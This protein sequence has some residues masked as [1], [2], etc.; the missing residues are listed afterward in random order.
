MSILSDKIRTDHPDLADDMDSG[1]LTTGQALNEIKRRQYRA[2]YIRLAENSKPVDGV[3]WVHGDCLEKLADVPDGS[4]NVLLTDPPYGMDY[5]SHRRAVLARKIANDKDE[6]VDVIE[7]M[8]KAVSPKL[9]P[10][11]HVLIFCTWRNEADM[12][13]IVEENGMTIK[14]SLI[15]VKNN[16]GS[17]DL[18]SSFAPKH[19]RIVHAIVGRPRV[20]PRIPDVLEFAKVPSTLHPTEKPA[21]LLARLIEVTC[22]EDGMV[23]DP[24]GGVGSILLGARMAKRKVWGCELDDQYYAVG[25]GRL[26]EVIN[27]E[28]EPTDTVG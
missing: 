22:P 21:D 17:G 4:I 1:K 28:V 2:K 16:H 19:E 14:G 13:R 8:I 7:E 3:T 6:A 18:R 27:E 25:K 24:F 15:W 26:V 9:A 11:A 5:Q 23:A 20:S 12:M 10:D